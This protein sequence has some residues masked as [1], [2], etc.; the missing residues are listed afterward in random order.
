MVVRGLVGRGHDVTLFAHPDSAVP[1]RLIKY[2]GTSFHSKPGLVR[3]T[4]LVSSTILRERFD[5]VH[6]F[7]RLAYLLPVLATAVPKV[8]TYQREVTPSR[9][10]WGG[11]LS[12]GTLHFTGCSRHLVRRYLTDSNNRCHVIYNGVPIEKYECRPFVDPDA[13]LVF[14]GRVEEI[15]GPHLAVEVSRRAGRNLVIGGNVPQGDAHA[16]F[17][18]T[19]IAPFVDGRHVQYVGPVDDA[20]KDRLLGGAAAL[21]M[22]ILW[23]EPFGIVMAEALACGTPVIALKRGSVPEIVE[24]GVNGFVCES[25]DEMARSVARLH[26]IDRRMC[27]RIMEERFS[28]TAVVNA[29]ERLY[30]TLVESTSRAAA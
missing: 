2:E 22:P 14:L 5:I 4:A 25:V 15:K 28:D 13:P 23:E 11:R 7:G 9:V 24:D 30:F 27:R 18:R 6:A 29:Y 16:N 3:N 1:C 8:M 19:A 17:F 20:G 26:E 10:R 12:R 21:L